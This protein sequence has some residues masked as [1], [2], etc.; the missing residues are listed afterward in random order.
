MGKRKGGIEAQ[1]GVTF[2]HFYVNFYSSFL[3]LLVVVALGTAA[4]AI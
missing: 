3:L 2:A 1:V 4:A